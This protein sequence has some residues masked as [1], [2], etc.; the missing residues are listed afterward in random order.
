MQLRLDR[1]IQA[2]AGRV[3]HR[4][5]APVS[6]GPLPVPAA[7]ITQHQTQRTCSAWSEPVCRQP[8]L[9]IIFWTW[10]PSRPADPGTA[11]QA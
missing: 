11:Q 1:H 2:H 7:G 3:H 10:R 8:F 4:N 6:P 9:K 5:S